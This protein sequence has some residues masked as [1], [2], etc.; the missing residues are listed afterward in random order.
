DQLHKVQKESI[1]SYDDIDQLAK[2]GIAS[3]QALADGMTAA[4]G[5][6]VTVAEAQKEVAAGAIHGKEAYADMMDGMM[7]YSG[8]AE[9]Q[10][11]S[12]GAEWQQLG[13][14]ASQLFGPFIEEL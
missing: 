1:A 3:W 10:S 11:R 13:E 8:A 9:Q 4:R 5:H 12:L 2:D 7:R 14:E 6:L